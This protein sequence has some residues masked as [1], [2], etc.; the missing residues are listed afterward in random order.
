MSR[1]NDF[2]LTEHF[3]LI[4]FQC[5]CCHT[6]MLNPQLLR[7]LEALRARRGGK[8]LIINSAFRCAS[9]NTDVGGVRGSLHTLG[10]AA[11]IRVPRAEQE[12]FC[13]DALKEG[14]RKALRYGPRGFVHLELGIR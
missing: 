4:E 13:C 10:Q 1:L 8:P 9:H 11:D 7:R 5:P 6:V 14:F 2:Q 3:N 12:S